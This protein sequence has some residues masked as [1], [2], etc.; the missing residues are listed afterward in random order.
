[1]QQATCSGT[2][3]KNPAIGEHREYREVP[4]W[5]HPADQI[6]WRAFDAG[7]VVAYCAEHESAAK[8]CSLVLR[9]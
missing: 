7:V 6:G 9:A 4:A 8:E 3:C 1:M 5:R 2:G